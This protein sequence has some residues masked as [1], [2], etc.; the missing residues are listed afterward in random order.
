MSHAA[1]TMSPRPIVG[2]ICPY[3]PGKPIEDVRRELGL[4]HIIKLASNENPLGPSPKV[5]SA[6]NRT[7]LSLHHYP[8]F[9]GTALRE[10]LARHLGVPMD[11]LILG[12]GSAELMKTLADTCLERGNEGIVADICFSVYHNVI[13]IAGA[14]PVVV[15]LRP[16]LSQDL[17]R[18][19]AAVTERTR[20]VFL[21]SPNNPTGRLVPFADLCAF[22]RDLPPTV[23]AALDLA[24]WEYIDDAQ[25]Y[26]LLPLLNELPN[27]VILRTFS[28][29]HGLAGLRV[30]YAIARP[31]VIRWMERVRIPFNTSTAAQVA[32]QVALSDPDHLARTLALNRAMRT[33]LVQGLEALGLTTWP[34]QANFVLADTGQNSEQVFSRFL[35]KGIIVRPVGHPRLS[36]CIRVTTGTEEEVERFLAEL[37]AVLAGP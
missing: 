30:G 29:A 37:P 31:E 13:S 6:L 25:A 4:I 34:S 33:R 14:T 20:I 5:V 21:A 11:H 3:E 22:V 28:K 12:A 15:P 36:T 19:R 7:N 32:A 24:Y 18:T 16:D 23:I 2:M 26:D 17:A 10:D 35:R 9:N 1:P 8:D 27:V